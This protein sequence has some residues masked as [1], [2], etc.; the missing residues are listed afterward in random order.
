MMERFAARVCQEIDSAVIKGGLGLELRLETPRTTK[1]ADLVVSGSANLEARLKQAGLLDLGDYLRFAVKPNKLPRF[2]VP[3]MR[4]SAER[5]DVQ[6]YFA[7]GPG[8]WSGSPYRKFAVEID[9]RGHVEFD[10][11]F[12]EVEGFPQIPRVPIRVLDLHVQIAEKVHAYTDPRH[13]E[14]GDEKVMRPRDL[15][16]MCR[17][18]ASERVSFD[19]ARLREAL[20]S[21]YE[22]RRQAAPD[23][24]LPDLP[25]ELPTMP[26]SWERAFKAQAEQSQLPWTDPIVAHRFAAAFINPVLAADARGQWDPAAKRWQ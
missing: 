20:G 6:A 25:R 26:Q 11:L 14:A 3:G 4:Y 10:Q 13:R 9:I 17:C 22:R 18:A 21:V 2:K 7:T 23:A 24:N 12:S 19:A 8:P 1:D 15:L 16:D 5:Y